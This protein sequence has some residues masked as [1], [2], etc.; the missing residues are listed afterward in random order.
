MYTRAAFGRFAAFEV[1]WLL[2]FTRAAS[3]AS[4]INVLVASLGFYWPALTRSGARAAVITA[5]IAAIAAINVR[6]IRQSSFVL[7]LLTI[8]K[9][10]PLRM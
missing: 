7:N 10:T 1:G 4:V 3:W 2:W 8:A 9:L 6:G 5:I